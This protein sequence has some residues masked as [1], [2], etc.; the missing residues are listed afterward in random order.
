MTAIRDLEKSLPSSWY[1][2]DGVFDIEIDHIFSKEWFVACRAESLP[3]IGDHLVLEW[4]GQNLLI[5]RNTEGQL[6]AF[7]NV[8]RHRGSKLCYES[9][10]ITHGGVT[11]QQTIVCPYHL[12]T[13]DLDGRLIKAPHLADHEIGDVTLYPVSL[14]EWG[15]FVFL[16]LSSDSTSFSDHIAIFKE[17]YCRYPLAELKTGAYVEYDVAA[18]WKILCENFNECYH[19]GPVHPELCQLVPAFREAGGADLDWEEG[20][21]HR[22]GATTFTASGESDR[23]SFPDLNE[24]EQTRHKGEIVYPNLFLSMSR[25]YVVAVILKPESAGRTTM[26]CYFLFETSEL[27]KETFNADDAIEFWDLINRQ[28]FA[29]CESVQQG[30]GSSAHEIGLYSPMEDWNLDIRHY[31][32]DR[33]GGLLKS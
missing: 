32:T 25:D 31:V 3:D 6:K 17:A 29:I 27:S 24:D 30:I 14:A 5:V 9:D 18:N 12:W 1:R 22:E 8:C 16:N 2:D 4:F 33:I 28:D 19:C 13:Y 10:V 26:C 21:P 7:H 11:K 20:I 15:G 23:R